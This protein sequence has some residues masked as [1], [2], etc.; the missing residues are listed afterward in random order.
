MAVIASPPGEPG[1]APGMMRGREHEQRIVL[2]PLLGDAARA[3][4]AQ[5]MTGGRK[6]I[7]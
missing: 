6:A 2:S 3:A 4:T 1:P 5:G 7:L